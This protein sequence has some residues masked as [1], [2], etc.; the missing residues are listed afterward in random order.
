LTRW[1]V[2]KPSWIVEEVAAEHSRPVT[3]VETMSVN[4]KDA[5]TRNTDLV[6]LPQVPVINATVSTRIVCAVFLGS[7]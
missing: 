6:A 1:A 7:S 2:A 3:D 4:L 5:E